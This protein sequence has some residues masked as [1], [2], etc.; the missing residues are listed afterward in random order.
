[1]TAAPSRLLG[2][3]T[4]R[5]IGCG[6]SSPRGPG[7]AAPPGTGPSSRPG[8]PPR[9]GGWCAVS[10]GQTQRPQVRPARLLVMASATTPLKRAW[11]GQRWLKMCESF[12]SAAAG[13]TA[14]IRLARASRP[15]PGLATHGPGGGSHHGPPAGGCGRLRDPWSSLTWMPA[16]VHDGRHPTWQLSPGTGRADVPIR[17]EDQKELAAL[18]GRAVWRSPGVM[19]RA[20]LL[21]R[22]TQSG[23]AHR[24][25]P[26]RAARWP[27]SA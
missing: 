2:T 17:I 26:G 4:T 22:R 13:A 10:G 14:V 21:D 12:Q 27:A 23:S 6:G 9:T 20:P 7:P 8:R 11:D 19:R 5:G 24:G 1:M 18:L 16:S 15:L 25:R 3:P